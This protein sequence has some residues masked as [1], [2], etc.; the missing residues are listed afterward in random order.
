METVSTSGPPLSIHPAIGI[1][2]VGDSPGNFHIGPEAAGALPTELDGSPVSTFKD[3]GGALR[4]QAARFHV[5]AGDVELVIGSVL[6]GKTVTDIVWTAHVA[7]K[8]SSFYDFLQLQGEPGYTTAV[9]DGKTIPYPL[10]NPE[11]KDPATRLATLVIDPG[12]REVSQSH[13]HAIFDKASAGSYPAKFPP[14]LAPVSITTLGELQLDTQGRLLLV[15][16]FGHSGTTGGSPTLPH[17]ANNPGW[18]DD[19]SDGPVS[20]VVCF[21]DGSKLAAEG[22][23]VLVTPPAYAPQVLNSVTLYDVMYDLFVRTVPGFRPDIYNDGQFNP[24]YAPSY[25]DEIFPLLLS[26]DTLQWVATLE[27]PGA[28]AER[29]NTYTSR[30]QAPAHE[31]GKLSAKDTLNA[32]FMLAVT[33]RDANNPFLRQSN[34]PAMPFVA[35][36]NPIDNTIVSKFLL[37]T[38]TQR[39]M[40]E[41]WARGKATDAKRPPLPPGQA[42]DRGVLQN[43]AGGAFCPGIE[44]GWIFRNPALFSAPFRID[45]KPVQGGLTFNPTVGPS[46]P[47][48][49]S[50]RMAQPWQADFNEC[51]IQVISTADPSVNVDTHGS[52]PDPTFYTLWWPAQRPM[53]IYSQP[54]QQGPANWARDEQ[55]N[56]LSNLDMA[57]QWSKLGFVINQGS[58]SAPDFAEVERSYTPTTTTTDGCR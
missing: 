27:Q 49:L 14:A 29:V 40:I 41:Q 9:V 32:Q 2:R 34:T 45:R 17:Y 13:A 53:S 31:F 48:D 5:F 10:R 35:G 6:G 25:P 3:P 52:P 55:G 42:I 15:G 24:D 11:V 30:V 37:F 23:W 26:A 33:R 39:F 54:G 46:E 47:G 19:V 18:F 56:E 50:Q 38:Q 58:Q 57:E 8:K 44:G 7:N 4:R 43:C 36:D 21:D 20:A 1:A 12:P 16:A 51:S 28:Y 22:A